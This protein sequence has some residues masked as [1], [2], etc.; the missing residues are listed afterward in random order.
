M[1]IPFK[2]QGCHYNFNTVTNLIR[3]WEKTVPLMNASE[4]LR[5]AAVSAK[6]ALLRYRAGQFNPL[7]LQG[8]NHEQET[9]DRT[10]ESNAGT[11]STASDSQ[12]A[13]GF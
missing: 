2:H 6:V 13:A 4:D 5:K 1:N 8:I 9:E 3:S 10:E 11:T 7:D 12:L